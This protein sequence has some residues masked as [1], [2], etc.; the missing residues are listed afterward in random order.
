MDDNTTCDKCARDFPTA[1]HLKRHLARKYPCGKTDHQCIDCGRSYQSALTLLR[2]SR[3][4]GV[5]PAQVVPAAA[6]A[7]P[8]AAP[9]APTSAATA[10]NCSAARDLH[11]ESHTTVINNY[12]V[13]RAPFSAP[14]GV[15][16]DTLKAAASRLSPAELKECQKGDTPALARLLTEI[17]KIVHTADPEAT[18]NVCLN[19]RRHDQVLVYVPVPGQAAGQAPGQAAG[20]APGQMDWSVMTLTSAL[21]LVFDGV[22]SRLECLAVPRRLAGVVDSAIRIQTESP[23]VFPHASKT[24]MYA[25]LANRPS[26]ADP[27]ADPAA[28]PLAP[29]GATRTGICAAGI[30]PATA[31]RLH[32]VDRSALAGALGCIVEQLAS[33]RQALTQLSP[34]ELSDLRADQVRSA[35]ML[36]ARTAWIRETREAR[37]AREAHR[38]PLDA[39]V[40]RRPYVGIFE[41]DPDSAAYVEYDPLTGGAQWFVDRAEAVAAKAYSAVTSILGDLIADMCEGQGREVGL[42]ATVLAEMKELQAFLVDRASDLVGKM[43]KNYLGAVLLRLASD[44]IR[45]EFA[46]T[47]W[48]QALCK[49]RPAPAVA[50]DC[51]K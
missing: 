14:L 51:G 16:L 35:A 22:V 30:P 13:H 39:A 7:A 50:S 41:L 5:V 32:G 17:V 4:C 46:T 37:E 44:H 10:T 38:A 47:P 11:V 15:G 23:F 43:A 27:Q 9:Q 6:Q 1:C 34:R 19:P 21:R 42:P 3:V 2:H 24:E 48:Y 18:D 31:V 29:A 49:L 26:K 8:A 25:H 40:E 45:A 28:R 36:V 33:T 20:Q 12:T